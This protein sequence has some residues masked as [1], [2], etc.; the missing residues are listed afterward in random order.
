[1][2]SMGAEEVKETDFVTSVSPI[3]TFARR[4]FPFDS[5]SFESRSFEQS[6]RYLSEERALRVR[7][8]ADSPPSIAP[9]LNTRPTFR[10]RTHP[11]GLLRNAC[12]LM[13][14]LL[15]LARN[16][17]QS[18][19]L[20]EENLSTLA[21]VAGIDK[22][23]PPVC[24]LH[25]LKVSLVQAYRT[26]ATGEETP[27]MTS[28]TLNHST[29]ASFNWQQSVMFVIAFLSTL[30]PE[31]FSLNPVTS[32]EA[33]IHEVIRQASLPTTELITH[34]STLLSERKHSEDIVEDHKES[35]TI[36]TNTLDVMFRNT[37]ITNEPLTLT[38]PEESDSRDR[39]RR[40]RPGTHHLHI[41]SCN[42][43]IIARMLEAR[44][45]RFAERIN[46]ATIV[47]FV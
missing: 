6:R 38:T 45:I 22:R 39:S 18:I 29:N 33:S 46:H 41:F 30:V 42:S 11:T 40:I 28:F 9:P 13:V 2:E 37:S 31:A 7:I 47:N 16:G 17:S 19:P 5:R 43:V 15:E 24:T 8:P 32:S 25:I 10:G 4:D 23:S 36:S 44:A 14:R 35:E 26:Y 21:G 20:T 34:I 27:A 12:L 1:M 3:R